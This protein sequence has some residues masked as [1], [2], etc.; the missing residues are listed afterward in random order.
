MKSFLI[1]RNAKSMISMASSSCSEAVVQNLLLVVV[2]CHSKEACLV[3]SAALV[4]CPAEEGHEHSTSQPAGEVVEEVSTSAMPTTFSG[5]SPKLVVPEEWAAM[6]IYLIYLG[7]WEV[8]A[9]EEEGVGGAVLVLRA[10]HRL[11][12][13]LLSN[14]HCRCP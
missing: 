7:T 6:T 4:A 11:L 8:V 9:S 13:L 12:R 1:P 5:I 2:V 10:V 3:D 14:V